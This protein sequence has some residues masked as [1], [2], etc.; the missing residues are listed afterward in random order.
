MASNRRNTLVQRLRRTSSGSAPRQENARRAN[1]GVDKD[2]RE[3]DPAAAA[4]ESAPSDSMN[5]ADSS[6]TESR[7][8]PPSEP[9]RDDAEDDV[10]STAEAAPASK[11]RRT[12]GRSGQRRRLIGM[13]ARLRLPRPARPRFARGP[14]MAVGRVGLVVCPIVA[15][16]TLALLA[17]LAVWSGESR[18]LSGLSGRMTVELPAT[19]NV[20]DQAI[21]IG[22]TL[23]LLNDWPGIAAAEPIDR[24]RVE[25]LLAPWFGGT[26]DLGALPL[27][28]LID[29]TVADAAEIDIMALEQALNQTVADAQL[30]DHRAWSADVASTAATLRLSAWVVFLAATVAFGAAVT[31][32]ATMIE[33]VWRPAMRE[34]HRLGA[35]ESR[36]AA[37]MAWNFSLAVLAGAAAGGLIGI[38]LSFVLTGLQPAPPITAAP[39]DTGSI[40]GGLLDPQWWHLAAVFI[41]PPI[42]ALL[43]A[44]T[45]AAIFAHRL[46][47]LW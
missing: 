19:D 8:A 27:P 3:T 10:V 34:M 15:V 21:E 35:D 39:F 26:Q 14:S 23:A 18:L 41:L 6:T 32:M 46:R 33:A 40:F 22:Q 24:D 17:I 7:P 37:P 36:I 1:D 44:L 42:A 25:A 38:G 47:Q 12:P 2:G 13:L 29:V 28:A 9:A 45:C 5:E 4:R 31:V 11:R 20:V 16:A 30:D 43:A